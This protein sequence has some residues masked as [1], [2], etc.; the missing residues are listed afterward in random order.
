MNDPL[1]RCNLLHAWAHCMRDPGTLYRR[2]SEAHSMGD[3]EMHCNLGGPHINCSFHPLA[4][5]TG[6]TLRRTAM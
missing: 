6:E 1:T 2:D 5:T 3:P 4:P